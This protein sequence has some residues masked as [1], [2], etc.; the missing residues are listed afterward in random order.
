M[1]KKPFGREQAER[2]GIRTYGIPVN[3][4]FIPQVHPVARDAQFS[5]CRSMAERPVTDRIIIGSGSDRHLGRGAF[6]GRLDRY[7]HH[8][9]VEHQ[10]GKIGLEVFGRIVPRPSVAPV[11][12]IGH[13]DIPHQ[14]AGHMPYAGLLHRLGQTGQVIFGKLRWCR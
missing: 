11:D 6:D 9:P 13:R 10:R 4:Q 2:A 1:Q 14:A 7:V 5:G 12:G 8:P 3:E